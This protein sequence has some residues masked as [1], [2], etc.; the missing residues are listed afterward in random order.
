MKVLAING[1][2]LKDGN[3]KFGL[4]LMK[5]IL[6][7]QG[8]EVEIF[9]IGTKSFHQCI[10]CQRCFR[11]KDGKCVFTDDP[12]NEIFAKFREVDGLILGSPIHF[13]G[14]AGGFKA[15]LDRLFY[16]NIANDNALRHK[17]GVSFGAVR[18]A[19]G[20]EACDQMNKYL[21]YAEMIIPTSDYWN[22][23]F[24]ASKG[25]SSKDTEGIRILQNLAQNMAWSLK[26]VENGKNTVEEPKEIKSKMLNMIR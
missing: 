16:V 19:G 11:E 13:A 1:S 15:L 4:N 14:M 22:V 17:V 6:E 10:D 18:R 9:D 12:V 21:Q 24:G 8:I 26:L 7:N 25:E 3:V 5:E 2:S 23:I 20:I